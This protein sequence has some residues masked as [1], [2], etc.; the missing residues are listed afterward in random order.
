[1]VIPL[2]DNFRFKS[3]HEIERLN[4]GFGS[5]AS[6]RQNNIQDNKMFVYLYRA[7][8]D[9]I[10]FQVWLSQFLLFPS[11]SI[12]HMTG[13]LF[14]G[15]IKNL[16]IIDQITAYHQTGFIISIYEDIKINK[17]I[18]TPSTMECFEN[19]SLILFWVPL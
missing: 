8:V 14:T 19:N 7:V 9:W 18:H 5:I 1:M 15:H 2:K 3:L 10:L 4:D 16:F 17:S 11:H 12:Y 13:M 6:I